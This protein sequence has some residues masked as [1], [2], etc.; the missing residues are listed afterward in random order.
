MATFTST[1]TYAN[2]TNGDL[3]FTNISAFETDVVNGGS[4]VQ[5]FTDNSFDP[6]PVVL[7]SEL[8]MSWSGITM[9]TYS[10]GSGATQTVTV[11]Y[12]VS[13]SGSDFITAID[14]LYAI[15]LQEGDATFVAVENIYDTNNILLATQTFISGGATPAPAQLLVGVQNA[16]VTLT[17]TETAGTLNSAISASVVDQLFAETSGTALAALGDYVWFDTNGNGVQDSTETGV[18]GVTVD[19]LNAAGTSVLGVTTTDATGFYHFDGLLP[20]TYE[21]K[22][23]APTGENFTL[24]SQGGNTAIDSNADQTTG[25]TAPVTLTA[26]QTDLTIDAGLVAKPAALG[27]YVWFDTNGNGLQDSTETGVAGV[28]VDLLDSSGTTVLGVTTTNASG[29][30]GFTNL[31]AGTYEVQFFAPTGDNF[32]LT[33]QG[34][35]RAVDS[36]ANTATGLTAPV[37]L[38]AG[39]T[40]LTIDAGLVAKPPTVDLTVAKTDG[41]TSVVA[42]TADTYTITVTNNGPDSVTSFNLVDAIPP[43]LLNPVFGTPSAGSYNSTTGLWSGVSL[44]AG[45]S[46]SITLS[47]TISPT[48]GGPVSYTASGTGADG[49]ESA[50]ATITVS[51]GQIIVQLTSNLANPTSAGQEVSG[52]QFTLGNT[53]V[54]ASLSSASG[55]LIDIANGGSVTA[56]GGTINNWGVAQGGSTLTLATAG[57]GAVG[58]SPI[59][60]IIGS[61]PYTNA[62]SSITGRNPQIQGTGTFVINA[63]GVTNC[64]QISGVRIEFG[65]GPD[66]I[67]A[68]T[69]VGGSGSITNTVTVTPVPGVTDTNPNNNTAT[70]TDTI[71]QS[72]TQALAA[73]GNY[74]WF[75]ADKDGLQDSNETG[76]AGVTVDLL[77]ATGTSVLGVT[78]TNASGAY[79]FT[80]LAAGTY[81]VKFVLPTGDTF[82]TAS[83]GTNRGID[84][85][86]DQTTGVTAPITLAAG[87]TDNSI[88]A[89][90]VGKSGIAINKT[91][92]DMVINTCSLETY[93]FNVTNTGVMPITNIG[94]K[95]NI[96][97]ASNPDYITPTA[98]TSYG[99]NVGDA[100]H[101]NALD[102]GETWKYQVTNRPI[103]NTPGSCGTVSHTCT[104]YNLGAGNTA[105]FSCSFTPT[106]TSDGTCYVFKDVSCHLSGTGVGSNGYNVDCPDAEVRFSS[107]CTK[108][109]TS[110]DTARN[111]WVTTLPAGC[112]PG[113]TFLTGCPVQVP[114]GCSFSNATATWTIG[115]SA[116]NC[117]STSV[118][119]EAAC[120]GYSSFNNNGKDGCTDYNAIGVKV[121]DTQDEY[122]CG[123]SLNT[124]YG[125]YNGCYDTSYSGWGWGYND[126]QGSQYDCAGTPENQYTNS[127]CYSGGYYS[128]CYGSYDNGGTGTGSSGYC[129]QTQVGANGAADTVTVTGSVGSTTLTASD[130]AEVMVIDSTNHI[131]TDGT[132][133]TSSLTYLYGKAQTLEFTY[134]PSDT[135]STHTISIGAA[136]GHNTDT[137]AFIE[138]SNNSNPYASGAQVYFEGS[139]SSGQKFYADA[140]INSLTNTANSGTAAFM[141]QVA[142]AKIFA[143]IFDSQEAFKAGAAPIQTDTYN[144]SGSQ[145]MYLNDQIASLKLVG[146][147]GS[148]GGHLVS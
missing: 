138:V 109:T 142:G 22:F 50:A 96:G 3:S 73:L 31:A 122:G 81:E 51:N 70:D 75:D 29:I 85:N 71:T 49:A 127:S 89:G 132:A 124:G 110:Y 68:T 54:S 136:T 114:S 13:A 140:G 98:V 2:L 55:T 117:G 94:L 27:D 141:S 129:N 102:V 47:G 88:D 42:G 106:K 77:N 12:D 95:D 10:D 82:T 34:A 112:T 25:L 61:G 52:I 128:G 6:S 83:V 72:G 147:V 76:V 103:E 121:C 15:D 126:Y 145:A 35:N 134:N 125:Y 118:N 63:P 18:A 21:V 37:T 137:M 97:S 48:A 87:Q 5:S 100:N 40:D 46:V 133:P 62:N 93:T 113:S 33:S 24:T 69:R 8:G 78:T 135:V 26:G 101:N 65:T 99:Y 9:E 20:G 19:L 57:T 130:T 116:N 44:G 66:C 119:W 123:G 45:Q 43:E 86:A 32:T 36:N 53:P 56:D 79:N 80:N 107:S 144:T 105:W 14:S 92:G 146:Y 139:V 104:G 67:L 108:A 60:L 38:T 131:S 17:M 23:I 120:K 90:L 4:F 59:D 11:S 16:H 58:G 28:T 7:G 41:K 115:N 64:T 39:Q 74:V 84:S 111:C 91:P 30:Y 1:K 143:F 148:T